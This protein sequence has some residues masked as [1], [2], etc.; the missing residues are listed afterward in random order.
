MRWTPNDT[1]VAW[2]V[3]VVNFRRPYEVVGDLWRASDPSR[4]LHPSAGWRRD[5]TPVG[6]KAWWISALA[7]ALVLLG[8]L[9]VLSPD[10]V[11]ADWAGVLALTR[12]LE[13]VIQLGAAVLG[14]ILVGDVVG[15]QRGRAEAIGWPAMSGY[16]IPAAGSRLVNPKDVGP[17]ES[18]FR[19]TVAVTSGEV[20][21]K[22]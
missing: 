13:H 21:G 5:P 11:S 4:A 14:F 9:T 16:R 10:S 6:L 22:Y 3:P 2:L 1:L 12:L 19:R 20:A 15:R 17:T 7:T 18:E 8:N